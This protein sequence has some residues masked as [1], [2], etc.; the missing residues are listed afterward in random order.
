MFSIGGGGSVMPANDVIASELG[1]D[2]LWPTCTC[3]M[4]SVSCK[5]GPLYL[6]FKL[7]GVIFKENTA[8]KQPCAGT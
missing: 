1:G 7:L 4:R 8:H 6:F 5:A 3:S 2:G